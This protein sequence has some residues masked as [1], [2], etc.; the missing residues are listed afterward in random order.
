MRMHHNGYI[1]STMLRAKLLHQYL[2]GLAGLKV[3]PHDDIS[4]PH[5]T[6]SAAAGGPSSSA[7][8]AAA[9]PRRRPLR[10]VFDK[11]GQQGEGDRGQEGG[12]QQQQQQEEQ[13]VVLRPSVVQRKRD[14]AE[15]ALP[16]IPSGGAAAAAGGGSGGE[17]GGA[18]EGQQQEQ[19]SKLEQQLGGRLLS[20]RDLWLDMP[21]ALALQVGWDGA[22]ATGSCRHTLAPC[23]GAELFA[24]CVGLRLALEVAT[25]PW[26]D[27]V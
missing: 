7:A 1:P 26:W 8:A 20:V 5:N 3:E 12:E 15:A 14:A 2:A 10:F 6:L 11:G 24:W 27:V 25:C 23:C 22:H 16:A 13:E 21:L 4:Y 18:S 17:A 9:Q 19:W